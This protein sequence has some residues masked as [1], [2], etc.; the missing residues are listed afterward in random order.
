MV[1]VFYV[2]VHRASNDLYTKSERQLVLYKSPKLQS[3]VNNKGYS[4]LSCC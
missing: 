1:L 3:S 2:F 4:S